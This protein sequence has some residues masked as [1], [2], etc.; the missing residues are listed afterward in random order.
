MTSTL[1]RFFVLFALLV[2]GRMTAHAQTLAEGP[3]PSTVVASSPEPEPTDP[4]Y[5]K[6][7]EITELK[8]QMHTLLQ[9]YDQ[10]VT[11]YNDQSAKLQLLENKQPAATVTT[12]NGRS[13]LLRSNALSGS[14]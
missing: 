10:L 3:T 4:R 14:Y 5:A 1:L 9:A 2:M 12:H 11:R 13:R 8:A 7:N 6:A